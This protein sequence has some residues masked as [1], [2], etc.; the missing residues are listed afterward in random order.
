[1]H[2]PVLLYFFCKLARDSAEVSGTTAAEH[3][4]KEK[5]KQ[6]ARWLPDVPMRGLGATFKWDKT[7]TFMFGN[8]GGGG[9]AKGLDGD[10]E[11][12]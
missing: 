5:R 3:K 7:M 1:M 4:R 10:E 11:G 8:R 2:P 9:R 12:G 6:R